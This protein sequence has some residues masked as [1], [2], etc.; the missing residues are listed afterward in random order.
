M[1]NP[2]GKFSYTF[3]TIILW[4]TYEQL[5]S[6]ICY[7]VSNQ[8]KFLTGFNWLF[9]FF[10]LFSSV[11]LLSKMKSLFLNLYTSPQ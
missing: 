5:L 2:L 11:I 1:G 6:L 10:F 9:G 7:C 3:S 4:S 8:K